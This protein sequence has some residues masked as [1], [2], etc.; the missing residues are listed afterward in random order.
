MSLEVEKLTF[1]S[2]SFAGPALMS[3]AQPETLCAPEF[4]ATV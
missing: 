4:S 3:V 2:D 1:W